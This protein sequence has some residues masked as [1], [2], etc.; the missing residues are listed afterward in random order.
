MRL[1]IVSAAAPIPVPCIDM[2]LTVCLPYLQGKLFSA[3]LFVSFLKEH[4]ILIEEGDFLA[5]KFLIM[6]V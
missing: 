6:K 3:C 2:A 1:V 5:L 4:L